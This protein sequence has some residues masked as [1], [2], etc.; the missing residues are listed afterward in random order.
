MC[1][2][3]I[4]YSYLDL[5][6]KTMDCVAQLIDHFPKVMILDR[7]NRAAPSTPLCSE[8]TLLMW[9]GANEG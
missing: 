4:E 9:E 5:T 8:I 1:S 2:F 3:E 6:T 7:R